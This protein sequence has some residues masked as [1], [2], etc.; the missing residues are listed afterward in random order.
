M[1]IK[2]L[3]QSSIKITMDTIE[4]THSTVFL[5]LDPVVSTAPKLNTDANSVEFGE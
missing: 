4:R 5:S 3:V 2:N 1:A